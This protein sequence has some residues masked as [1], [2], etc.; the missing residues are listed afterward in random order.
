MQQHKQA[1]GRGYWNEPDAISG[2]PDYTL[3]L[4]LV[5]VHTDAELAMCSNQPAAAAAGQNCLPCSH[6][7]NNGPPMN[8]NHAQDSLEPAA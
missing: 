6:N 2:L 5:A 1:A 8:K 3:A 4:Q 7:F